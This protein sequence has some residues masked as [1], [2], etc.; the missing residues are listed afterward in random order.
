MKAL[1]LPPTITFANHN[2]SISKDIYF[3]IRKIT[4]DL[5]RWHVSLSKLW[6]CISIFFLIF[7]LILFYLWDIFI[8]IFVKKKKI[9]TLCGSGRVYRLAFSW[10][11][12]QSIPNNLPLINMMEANTATSVNDDSMREYQKIKIYSRPQTTQCLFVSMTL[13][14]STPVSCFQL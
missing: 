8:I 13:K 4:P 10:T 12:T 6:L 5:S 9:H 14:T 11:N 1:Q 2:Q 7:Y 3:Y